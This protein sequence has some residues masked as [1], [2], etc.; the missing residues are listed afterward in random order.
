M[1]AA[2]VCAFLQTTSW[3]RDFTVEQM[4]EAFRNSLCFSLREEGKQIGFAR[5]I[6][7]RVTF[8][9]LCDVYIVEDCRGRGL[10]T[11]LVRCALEHPTLSRLRRVALITHDA[12]EFYRRLG[13]GPATQADSYME[14]VLGEMPV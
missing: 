2:A 1:D 14:K 6:T 9:Y 12:Q 3:A 5:V 8:A 10:G 13:F 7:D 11:W 4:H